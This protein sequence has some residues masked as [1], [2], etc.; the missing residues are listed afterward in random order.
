MCDSG[1][2]TYY[3]HGRSLEIPKGEGEGGLKSQMF[4]KK[5]M[6][7]N[8]NFLGDHEVQNKT[9]SVGGVCNTIF[10]GTTQ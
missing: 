1:K 5:S 3:P 9:P 6:K 8:C 10:S 4:R 7:L 2:Y